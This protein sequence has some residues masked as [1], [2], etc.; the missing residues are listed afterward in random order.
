[1][2]SSR[3]VSNLRVV[4]VFSLCRLPEELWFLITKL[5]S[6]ADLD[7]LSLTCKRFRYFLL[8][9]PPRPCVLFPS[10]NQ[11][12]SLYQIELKMAR[13]LVIDR[14][15]SSA[16]WVKQVLLQMPNLTT[17]GVATL[18]ISRKT[19]KC[20]HHRL[21]KHT[22]H[23]A[24]VIKVHQKDMKRWT[25]VV[26]QYKGASPLTIVALDENPLLLNVVE[27]DIPAT[28]DGE[29]FD[30][31]QSLNQLRRSAIAQLQTS[32]KAKLATP[33]DALSLNGIVLLQEGGNAQYNI[34]LQ[35]WSEMLS[36]YNHRFKKDPFTDAEIEVISSMIDTFETACKNGSDLTAAAEQMIL[37][38]EITPAVR[39]HANMLRNFSNVLS[40]SWKPSD[41]TEDTLTINT[42][43]PVAA[44]FL[45]NIENAR[46][47]GNDQELGSSK[48][49]KSQQQAASVA[50]RKPDRSIEV[51]AADKTLYNVYLMEIKTASK[52]KY[53]PDLVKLATMMKDNCDF[54]LAHGK[55][56]YAYF[57]VGM[58]Q[59]GAKCS[60]YTMN[61]PSKFFYVLFLVDE[62][63]LPM[64]LSEMSRLDNVALG[65]S[66]CRCL[67]LEAI[68]SLDSPS[69]A[70]AKPDI[71]LTSTS[72]AH[73]VQYYH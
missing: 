32:T 63:D 14:D 23:R 55:D 4:V 30:F 40:K 69:V 60:L 22:P 24:R 65:F 26:Q 67:L 13:T 7:Q 54:A 34:E 18:N 71:R 31:V 35:S 51:E 48:W 46:Y 9:Y 20:L 28:A 15:I 6:P 11:S 27:E 50:G 12:Q 58:L 53:R 10:P 66:R 45:G 57:S 41:A 5:L 49:R 59:E 42:Y 38:V 47:S 68:A 37:P 2:N 1:M 61:S 19:I 25:K 44:A 16:K 43:D 72:P 36:N 64:S 39:R 33:Q 3:P 70:V 73:H 29:R 56:R 8:K 52:S 62:F 17:V 21:W